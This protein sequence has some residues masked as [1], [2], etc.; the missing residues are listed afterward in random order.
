MHLTVAGPN[1]AKIPSDNDTLKNLIGALHE[2]GDVHLPLSVQSFA[3]ATFKLGVKIKIVDDAEE[4]KVLGAV[5]T[6]L[7]TDYSFEAREFGQPV[8]LGEIY[9][10]IHAVPGVVAAD[11]N[12]LYRKGKLIKF[13]KPQ[14]R[15]RLFATLPVVQ[16][17]GSVTPAEMLTLD[18]S[19]IDLGVMT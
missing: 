6:A 3:S 17:D 5:K 13:Q 10:T 8:T 19:P 7:R 12:M 1:G 16:S 2:F 18:P 4:A 14:P 9:A 15:P 11:I